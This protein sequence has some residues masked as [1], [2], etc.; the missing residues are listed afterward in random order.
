VRR[1]A[2]GQEHERLAMPWRDGREMATVECDDRARSEGLGECDHR[3][4]CSP[5]REVG[6][7]LRELGHSR[8]VLAAWGLDVELCDTAQECALREGA[9]APADEVRRLCNHQGRGD[10]TQILARERGQAGG[11]V[12]LVGVGGGVKRPGVN[13]RQGRASPRTARASS[14]YG[15]PS[16]APTDRRS[17]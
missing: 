2:L 16:S 11:V 10:D 1:G 8:E 6:V 12:A 17:I 3:G 4:V 15:A 13:D 7:L 14:P 5:E 9:E